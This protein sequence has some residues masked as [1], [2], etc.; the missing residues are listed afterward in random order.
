MYGYACRYLSREEIRADFAAAMALIRA[1]VDRGIPVLAWGCGGVRTKKGIGQAAVAVFFP[2]IQIGKQI[3]GD[4][5]NRLKSLL[6]CYAQGLPHRIQGRIQEKVFPGMNTPVMFDPISFHV[7]VPLSLMSEM[8]IE[9]QQKTTP[10]IRA[11]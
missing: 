3:T 6:I 4:G 2:R 10:S 5:G 11:L 7:R 8:A 9:Y 1:S